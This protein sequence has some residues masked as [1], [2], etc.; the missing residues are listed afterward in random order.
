MRAEVGPA[1]ANNS[2]MSLLRSV[3]ITGPL[4]GSRLV[5]IVLAA[6]LFAGCGAEADRVPFR[7]DVVISDSAGADVSCSVNGEAAGSLWA[8]TY[9]SLDDACGELDDAPLQLQCSSS[10]GQS[11]GL[12][13][14]TGVC[15]WAPTMLSSP[16]VKGTVYV[17]LR[18][19]DSPRIN[20]GD[21]IGA[22]GTSTHGD[23]F[24][25]AGV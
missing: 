14:V 12:V 11:Y 9:D 21:C 25:D 7:L 16:I 1:I 19:G 4:P 10:M 6:A 17:E 3:L 15:C 18:V 2:I 22:D 13:E 24:P 5:P 20:E 23:T 8:H